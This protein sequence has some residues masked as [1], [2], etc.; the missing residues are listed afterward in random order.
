MKNLSRILSLGSLANQSLSAADSDLVET[1]EVSIQPSKKKNPFRN[2][3]KSI[4]INE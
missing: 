4:T 2:E 3:R 1:G